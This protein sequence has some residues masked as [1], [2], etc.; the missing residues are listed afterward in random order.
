MDNKEAQ[1]V[2][3]GD[4]WL[5]MSEAA[6]H[7]PYSSEYL[8]LLARKGKISAKKIDNTWYT[9]RDILDS[10]MKKQMLLAQVQNG[11]ISPDHISAPKIIPTQE[12][13]PLKTVRSYA[14]DSRDYDSEIEKQNHI[15]SIENA[16]ERVVDKKFGRVE[17]YE[18]LVSKNFSAFRDAFGSKAIVVSTLVI[19]VLF[20]IIPIPFAFSFFEKGLDF[21][22]EL[23][24][25]ANTIMGYRPGTHKN[26]I[27]L[28]D[29]DGNISIFGHIESHV[30][31]GTAP[32]VVDSKTQ[33]DNL[34]AE[35]LN[36]MHAADFTLAFVTQNGNVTSEDVKLDGTVEVGK[37]LVV[38]GA[39]KLLSALEVGGGLRVFGDAEIG[40]ALRVVGPASFESLVTVKNNLA[41][42]RN[43]SIRGGL[44]IGSGIEAKSAAFSSVGVSGTVSAA[45]GKFVSAIIDD[46]SA[47]A[48]TV[49]STTATSAVVTNLNSVNLTGASSSL[50]YLTFD[51]ATGTSATTTNLFSTYLTAS[52]ATTTTLFVNKFDIQQVTNGR[53][54]IDARRVT[55]S[56]PSGD[57]ITYTNAAGNTALFRVDNSGNI[58]AGG[59]TNSGALTITSAVTPQFRIQYDPTNENTTSVSSAGVTT[60]GFNGT[61]P[62]AIWMPQANATGTFQFQDS[63]ANT[64]LDI[65]TTNQRVGIGTTSPATALDLVGIEGITN[66]YL[67]VLP[68][69]TSTFNAF[70]LKGRNL[71]A[72]SSVSVPYFVPTG[73]NTNQKL[74]LDLL[75]QGTPT[76]TVERGVAWIDITDAN[77]TNLNLGNYEAL[78]IGKFINGRGNISMVAGGTGVVRDLVLQA[79]GGRVGIG[80]TT[81]P[82]LLSVN[83]PAGIDSLYIGS[84]TPKLI[85]KHTGLVGIGTAAPNK[86]LDVKGDIAITSSTSPAVGLER[87][88][89]SVYDNA[90][91]RGYI[92]NYV[93]VGVGGTNFSSWRF[94]VANNS[95][96]SE[97]MTID[98]T[99]NIGI[100]T[101][102]PISLLHLSASVVN[103]GLGTLRLSRPDATKENFIRFDTNNSNSQW[104]IGIDDSTGQS[105][106]FEIIPNLGNSV[107]DIT[108]LGNVGIGTTTP[109]YRLDVLS[110]TG[111]TGTGGHDANINALAVTG[112]D[113]VQT[114]AG[115]NIFVTTNSDFAIDRGGSIG[116][117][118]RYI[119]GSSNDL[120]FASIKGAKENSTSANQ[121]GYLAF[122]TR[123]NNTATA[124]ERMRIDSS[125]NVGIGT[126]SP[127]HLLDVNNSQTT[128]TAADNALVV[129]R[130]AN[131]SAT[132]Q[133]D[134]KAGTA[135]GGI[136]FAD[137]GVEKGR[138]QLS[139]SN[140]SMNFLTNG[141][142]WMTITS[143]GNV[144]I[145]A[146]N[147]TSGK[148]HMQTTSA[149]DT[150]YIE[151]VTSGNPILSLSAAGV[152]GTQLYQDRTSNSFRI[153]AE[154]GAD[155]LTITSAG[156][157]GI[158]TT[159]PGSLGSG[160]TRTDLQ[161]HNAG[162]DT[163]SFGN[164][165]LS[166]GATGADSIMGAIQFGS[167][168]IT[169]SVAQRT[170]FIASNK[171]FASASDPGGNLRFATTLTG[172]GSA[173][174]ERM[175]IT[176]SG[177]VGVGTT[178]PAQLLSV[179]GSLFIGASAAGG[180]S[181]GLGVGVVNTSAGS[182]VTTGTV[183]VGNTINLGGTTA[184]SGLLSWSGA[185]PLLRAAVGGSINLQSDNNS[186]Q[187]NFAADGS[188]TF[189]TGAVSGIT[190]L[191]TTGSISAVAGGGVN[192]T[193]DSD[194]AGSGFKLNRLGAE[195]WS[196]RNIEA[197]NFLGFFDHRGTPDYR[198]VI[199]DITG[200][201][202]IGT[203]TPNA[204]LNIVG[205]SSTTSPQFSINS[206]G[207]IGDSAALMVNQ[208]AKFGYDGL[209][210]AVFID[211][212][213]TNKHIVFDTN[214]SEKMRI[215]RTGEVGIGT[216]TPQAAL[217]VNGS[218]RLA[219]GILIQR[220]AGSPASYAI[221]NIRGAAEASNFG[222]ALGNGAV[223]ISEF[224]TAGIIL[225][226]N[227]AK[228]LAFGTANTERMR[229]E[230][231]GTI[232]LS[233]ALGTGTGGNYLCIDTTTFE[234]LRGNGA[235]CTASSLRFKENINDLNYGLDE[236]LA[237]RPVSY[238]YKPET[239][240]GSGV[241]LGFIAEEMKLVIPEVVTVDNNGQ[242]FGLDY[243]VL[244][245]V[246]TK[247]I[248]ELN[249]KVVELAAALSD[250][251]A[252]IVDGVT[253]FARLAV[254]NLS[255]DALTLGKPEKPAG[256]TI[257]DEANGAPFCIKVVSGQ[258]VTVPG[259]CGSAA[260]VA[261]GG[262]TVTIFTPVEIIEPTPG[263]EASTTLPVIEPAATS[264]PE[265]ASST[266]PADPEPVPL[267]SAST[268]SDTI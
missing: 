252:T 260:L 244:T 127:L 49:S 172:S 185:S 133:L 33:V 128:N 265:T 217:E 136:S 138:I 176:S 76:D 96:L 105:S 57:F 43:V 31:N 148:L 202:G 83:D 195:R 199:K 232:K 102:T 193:V 210:S 220:T 212:V 80:T 116:F 119:T 9:T 218:V 240:M 117:G 211:D 63:S 17:K 266:P 19:I 246:L 13:V 109:T 219:T 30:S 151:T 88:R 186:K 72:G 157:V 239:N 122:A 82:A 225:G 21:V 160:G 23:A 65:D 123:N 69:N 48:L 264:T 16:L 7:T 93:P 253:H 35:Y 51:L 215:T 64:I 222:N 32:I 59:I 226:T 196:I 140:Y 141:T 163:T 15:K 85:V 137:T 227:S 223:E 206:N 213:A 257:Y 10:Y 108:T 256:I 14:D 53:T 247:A 249:T 1:N 115:G 66:G 11:D 20:T 188:T 150:L 258:T 4:G 101:T 114:S 3:Q 190:T 259:E 54:V 189:P 169:G 262:P 214:G 118:G 98:Y 245:S 38:S 237:L 238:N 201:V 204:L 129:I 22:K 68:V 261:G 18:S 12:S 159:T 155:R 263:L 8:S 221:M 254:E 229:I 130:S 104:L 67:N 194:A 60:F 131:R 61:T 179:G 235:A 165:M 230:S 149:D 78:S 158:G 143:T 248:Q 267:T 73:T 89:I 171:E 216:S 170:A 75:V 107:F 146:T 187:W 92:S 36:D 198:M 197:S 205:S 52:G 156:N 250:L 28:L 125:G 178:S 144:G 42:Q 152:G 200:F 126:T 29:K 90:I 106:N 132:L 154:G 34:N 77:E 236:V 97:A 6:L 95:T 56:A 50:A 180:T 145:G 147:P 2:P 113:L 166:S 183:S 228:P 209:R 208:R 86:K 5:S 94:T 233:S 112:P 121:N 100:G 167:A 47:G 268:T 231:G 27:L 26:E 177:N 139:N 243:P 70:A 25:D 173:P 162:T 134:A 142:E 192:I 37:T 191:S 81:P 99:G 251:G 207:L 234:V 45:L 39:T 44:E 255:V 111:N 55:D 164:L 153:K 79:G 161:I 174:T 58:F 224:T 182:I 242:T 103:S 110:G 135:F 175:R 87:S 241:K 24:S 184:P 203:T 124:A 91:E 46:I 84:S 40:K 71:S 62:R 120:S 168:G 41:V 181:G 74:A